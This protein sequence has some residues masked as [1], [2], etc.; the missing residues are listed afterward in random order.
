[1][2]VERSGPVQDGTAQPAGPDEPPTVA[3][4]VAVRLAAARLAAAGLPSPRVDAEV[5]AAYV[6]GVERAR[7][8][9]APPFGDSQRRRYDELIGQRSSLVPVQHLTGT[10]GFRLLDLAVGPGV[11]VPRPETELLVEWGL[12]ALAGTVRPVVVDLC[13]GS[14]AIAL[15]IA[16]ELPGA[17]VYAVEREPFA[18]AWLHRNAVERAAAGDPPIVVVPGDATDPLVAADLDGTVDLVLINPPYVPDGA[19]LPVDVTEHDPA[20]AL[21]GGP[22]GLVVVRGLIARAAILLRPGGLLGL[23]HADAQGHAVPALLRR[24]GWQDVADHEDLAG[25]PRFST[26]QRGIPS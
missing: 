4:T 7:L 26:G 23:E 21:F 10:A 9:A 5:L 12:S 2:P 18:L 20:A 1:M 6:A 22:D 17:R 16:Q 19:A 11:F 3:V 24:S 25:R 14:G 8:P 15:S 13:A